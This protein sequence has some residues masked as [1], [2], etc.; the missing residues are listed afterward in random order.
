MTHPSSAKYCLTS[1]WNGTD[2]CKRS[3]NAMVRMLLKSKVD[4]DTAS[5]DVSAS[6]ACADNGMEHDTFN[7]AVA[8]TRSE[9]CAGDDAIEAV[10]APGEI[11]LLFGCFGSED[12]FTRTSVLCEP[13]EGVDCACISLTG[14]VFRCFLAGG[15]LLVTNEV[16]RLTTDCFT[17]LGPP[18]RQS[19]PA[20]AEAVAAVA[21]EE[22]DADAASGSWRNWSCG[23]GKSIVCSHGCCVDVVGF[24]MWSNGN[25][26]D[27]ASTAGVVVRLKGAS[28]AAAATAET[29]CDPSSV[30]AEAASGDPNG[31]AATLSSPWLRQAN[32]RFR[33]AVCSVSDHMSCA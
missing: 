17:S 15:F 28:P 18:P 32:G 1:G 21:E 12:G 11:R 9:S 25:C 7:M 6:E 3:A 4:V 8:A 20:P 27:W 29:P 24:N 10:G 2:T 13:A 23:G 33:S 30:V 19:L 26:T 31:D 16:T 14:E 22:A 5:G